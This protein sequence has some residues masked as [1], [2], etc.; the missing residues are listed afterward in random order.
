MAM[1]D[2]FIKD[3]GWKFFSL[4]LAIV[5]WVTVYKTREGPEPAVA[6]RAENTYGNLPVTVVSST[7]DVHGFH[8]APATVS[9]T[10]RGLSGVMAVL[11]AKQIHAVVDL[12]GIEST[13]DLRRHVDVSTPPGVTLVNVDPPEVTVLVPPAQNRIP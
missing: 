3:K 8:V 12:T 13:H 5:I 2:W 1:R 10:V 6:S 11:Q 7:A 4:I 9:V